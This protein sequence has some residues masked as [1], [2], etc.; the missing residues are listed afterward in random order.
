[1][2]T[3]ALKCQQRSLEIAGNYRGV[4]KPQ[5]ACLTGANILHNA[6]NTLGILNFVEIY[7]WVLQSIL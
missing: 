1:M 4:N 2:S 6:I 7:K 5:K 3:I